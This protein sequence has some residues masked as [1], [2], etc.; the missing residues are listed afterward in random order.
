MRHS[1]LRLLVPVLLA[2]LV[3]GCAANVSYRKAESAEV[4]GNWDEA[5]LRYLDALDHDPGNIKFRGALLRAKIKASQAH[6]EKGK[7]FEKANV[8]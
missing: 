6:F 3:A 7:Q 8:L 1:M 2:A 5:V 4:A